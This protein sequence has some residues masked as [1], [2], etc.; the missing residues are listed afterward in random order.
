[1]KGKE[2]GEIYCRLRP[3]IFNCVEL[4]DEPQ[5]GLPCFALVILEEPQG[6]AV[7]VKTE[8]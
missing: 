7:E 6:P 8:N 2:Y 4:G 3:E 5:V 1:M